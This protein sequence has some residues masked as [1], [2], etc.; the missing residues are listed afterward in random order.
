LL[1]W[2]RKLI[3]DKYDG[4]AQRGPG[5]PRTAVEIETLVVRLAEENREWG[6]KNVRFSGP[7]GVERAEARWQDPNVTE[8]LKKGGS[9]IFHQDLKTIVADQQQP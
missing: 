1:A 5:R 3:A 8:K 9:P 2:H 4:T 7:Y 6:R